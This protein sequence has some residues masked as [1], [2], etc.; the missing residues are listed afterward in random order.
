MSMM[1]N[2]VKDK[3]EFHITIYEDD[4]KMWANMCTKFFCL[5]FDKC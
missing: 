3:D 4:E 1:S 5:G 2:V